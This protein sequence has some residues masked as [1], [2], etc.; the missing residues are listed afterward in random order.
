MLQREIW[1]QTFDV[2]PATILQVVAHVGGVAAGAFDAAGALAGFV[3][4][5]TGVVDDKI[6]HWSHV[7]GVRPELRNAGVGRVLKE[8]QRR[9]LARRHIGEMY[10]TYDPSIAKNAH[11]NVNV[12]GARVVRFTPDMYG[13]TGS[14]LHHGLPTDRL[15]VVCD[16]AR[17]A[18]DASSAIGRADARTPLLTIEP[19]TG[20]SVLDRGAP[21]PLRARL[22]IPSDF[23][24]LL[25]DAPRDARAWHTATREHF[26]WALASGYTVTGFARDSETARSFY[27]LERE[28]RD[29]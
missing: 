5:V 25:A 2:M 18:R 19:R 21:P 23:A 28:L 7:L 11:F 8:Y 9:D 13:D 22:E 15:V 12:L 6:I 27:L 10:W 1:G 20:D 17:P 24:Q 26:Q 4:G 16:T 14:P 3:F 29:L